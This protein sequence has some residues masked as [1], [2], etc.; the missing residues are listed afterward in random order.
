MEVRLGDDLLIAL[1]SPLGSHSPNER[2]ARANEA[3][4]SALPGA[5]PEDV[6]LVRN[7]DLSILF[8]GDVAVLELSAA[9]AKSHGEV[10]VETLAATLEAKLRAKI[11]AERRREAITNT[12]LSVA[13]TA[14]LGLLCL[15]LVRKVRA[16]S[17]GIREWLLDN[18]DDVP[19]FRLFSFE[20]LGPG[21]V[22]RALLVT[23]SA[24][25]WLLQFGLFYTYLV[26]S[27]SLF[28]ST[29]GF[30][31]RLTGIV[32]VPLSALTSRLAQAL[33]VL[34]VAALVAL[35]VFLVLR[36]L[37]LLFESVA[38]GETQLG[39]IPRDFAMP[40]GL[41][42]RIGIVL[43][44]VV[45]VAPVVTG[46]P[47]GPVART[48]MLALAGLALASLPLLATATV[49]GATLFLRRLEVGQHVEFGGQS[50]RVLEVGLLEVRLSGLDGAEVRVPHLLG[51]FRPTRYFPNKA[52][53]SL[54]LEVPR[55]VE[56]TRL[57]TALG[58]LAIER[59]LLA[60][61]ELLEIGPSSWTHRIT[62][63]SLGSV[64][65]KALISVVSEGLE[66][67]EIEIIRLALQ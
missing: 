53:A 27:L 5:K 59:P 17:S 47:D 22:Q 46:E 67:A 48:G 26:V 40:L 52:M 14:F 9:D 39:G 36:F 19:A 63:T 7:A 12:A 37:G 51:L 50:G 28:E 3:L 58:S 13:L 54:L 56:R 1:K 38:R 23:V 34:F 18:A 43:V 65:T 41:V 8:V 25:R 35:A 32:L 29:R 49:G 44:A 57:E 24:A 62:V 64:P 45:F 11:T 4:K 20:L 16:V 55:S 15:Y 60:H 6:R 66:R 2:A 42:L 31:S 33:P 30:T 61:L 10:S 21:P